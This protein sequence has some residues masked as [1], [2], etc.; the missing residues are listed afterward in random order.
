MLIVFYLYVHRLFCRRDLFSVTG[1][2]RPRAWRQRRCAATAKLKRRVSVAVVP[3]RI[4]RPV[5][6]IDTIGAC[7]PR[8]LCLAVARGRSPSPGAA[9]EDLQFAQ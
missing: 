5:S 1:R 8:G 7:A 3:H 9:R 6:L 2:L 4:L